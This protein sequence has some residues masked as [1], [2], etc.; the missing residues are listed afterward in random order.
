MMMKRV[1]SVVFGISMVLQLC[2]PAIVKAQSG[3]GLEISPPLV[4]L[5]TDPG[6]TITTTIRVRNVTQDTLVTKS[7]INDFV[8]NGEDGQPKLLLN[9][10]EERPYS[11]KSWIVSIPAVTLKK[12]EQKPIKVTLRVPDNASPGGHFGVVR[13]TGTPPEL[14][15]TGVS[16]SASVG[17]LML[18]NV[19][20]NTTESAEV[21]ELFTSQNGKRR[22]LFEYGPITITERIKNTGNVFFKPSGSVRVS[23]IFGREVETFSINENGGN[24]LPGSTRKFEQELG[25]KLLF[26]RYTVQA[27]IVYGEKNTILTE[28]TSFWVIPYKLI[29]IFL[30]GV[31]LAV[32]FIKRYNKYIV[33]KAQGKSGRKRDGKKGNQ[34]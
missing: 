18:V 19:S 17:T 8:A 9:A 20:G 5:K 7:E 27:D 28:S 13:F 16:L 23:N 26:G 30:G 22:S 4:E 1:F 31:L 32:L 2:I 14:E 11:I 10:D 21:S 29:A 24:V 12:G 15:D 25:N 34:A 33:N 6:K 3:Q